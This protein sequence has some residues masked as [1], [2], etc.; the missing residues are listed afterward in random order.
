[1]KNISDLSRAE[2]SNTHITP[3]QKRPNNEKPENPLKI[4]HTSSNFLH[5]SFL[6]ARQ[7]HVS[8]QHEVVPLKHNNVIVLFLIH[9]I[10]CHT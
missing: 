8:N 5:T 4:P 10:L 2:A 9:H 6:S 3:P 1:M 7:Y